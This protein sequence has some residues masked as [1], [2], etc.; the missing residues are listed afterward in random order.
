MKNLILISLM[1]LLTGCGTLQETN[2]V[3]TLDVASADDGRPQFYQAICGVDTP[4]KVVDFL[5]KYVVYT[6]DRV[7]E[8]EFKHPITTYE[9]GTGD[10]EDLAGLSDYI[11]ANHFYDTTLLC[12]FRVGEGHAV[13]IFDGPAGTGY[14]D[15]YTVHYT[16]DISY[17]AISKRVYPDYTCYYVVKD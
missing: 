8:D 12:V 16:D 4:E 3:E 7:P 2:P 11:L 15:N 6:P 9:D 5:S 10:C 13:T 17:K 1:I 14:I